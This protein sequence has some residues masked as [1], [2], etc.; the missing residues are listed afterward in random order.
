MLRESG[1]VA[2]IHTLTG[3]MLYNICHGSE[4]FR[5]EIYMKSEAFNAKCVINNH[6]H[7]YFLGCP[8]SLEYEP[9]SWGNPTRDNAKQQ[10][11]KLELFYV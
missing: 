10:K 1:V 3:Y 5:E 4:K 2:V 11:M 6:H 7:Y 9:K 8:V